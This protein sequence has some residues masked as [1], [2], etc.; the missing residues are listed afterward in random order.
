[1]VSWNVE[2]RAGDIPGFLREE[3]GYD[4][5]TR[6][7]TQHFVILVQEAVRRSIR[8][9]KAAPEYA[10][11]L[12]S[13][14]T[15]DRAD[16]TEAAREC[17]LSY[18][19]VPSMRNGIE[20]YADGREDRGNAILASLPLVD[21]TAIELPF[22]GQR[23]VAVMASIE[24]PVSRDTISFVSLHLDTFAGVARVLLTGGSSKE[25]QVLG[26]VDALGLDGASSRGTT[27][28]HTLLVAGDLNTWSERQTAVQRLVEYFP[29]SPPVDDQPTRGQFPTDHIFAIVGEP[30]ALAQDG[31]D[32]TP[33]IRGLTIDVE[34]YELIADRYLSDHKPR[35]LRLTSPR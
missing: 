26:L 15:R 20:E 29:D 21:P 6:R 33:F 7:G 30:A 12:G 8:V 1:V 18:L 22:E 31:N 3:L 35:L 11:A 17:G 34:S 14:A 9:P 4:C 24:A 10:P 13:A 25:R 27:R 16:F 28:R 2:G 32:A 19:Y 5:G 23:R